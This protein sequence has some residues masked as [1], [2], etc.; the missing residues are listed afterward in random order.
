[1]P[2]DAPAHRTIRIRLDT[3]RR[4]KVVAA[5]LGLKMTDLID[6][7]VATEEGQLEAGGRTKKGVVS[8]PN[9]ND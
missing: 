1:M 5:R 9:S 7:W 8:E 4:L 3:Y 6:R 2:N